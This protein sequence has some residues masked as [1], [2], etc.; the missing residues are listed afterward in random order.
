[1]PLLMLTEYVMHGSIFG[2]GEIVDRDDRSIEHILP[3]KYD[4]WLE[5]V[6]KL[7]D[8]NYIQKMDSYKEKIGNYL[9]L[10][11]SK[12]QQQTMIFLIIKIKIYIKIWHQNY[13]VI[14]SMMILIFLEKINEHL[15]ILTNVQTH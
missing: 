11:K 5:E 8:E 13:I 1:M 3:Q 2:G 6:N 14:M 9:I 7:D 10:S 12:T 4:K 15:K